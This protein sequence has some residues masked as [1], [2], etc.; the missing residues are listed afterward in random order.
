MSGSDL[1]AKLRELAEL[2]S[3]GA[4]AHEEFTLLKIC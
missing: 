4:I 3:S 1:V 2:H